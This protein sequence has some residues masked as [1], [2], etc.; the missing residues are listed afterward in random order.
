MITTGS[1]GSKVQLFMTAGN[2]RRVFHDPHNCALGSNAQIID[3]DPLP[4]H[5][6]R[7]TISVQEANFRQTQVSSQGGTGAEH[8]RRRNAN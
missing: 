2:G 3:L 5:S 4:V 1:D 7:E 8:L 6:T